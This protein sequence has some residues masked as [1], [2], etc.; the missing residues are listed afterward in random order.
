MMLFSPGVQIIISERDLFD[1]RNGEPRE[2]VLTVLRA[3]EVRFLVVTA[4]IQIF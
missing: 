2:G 3:L 4:F 1:Y